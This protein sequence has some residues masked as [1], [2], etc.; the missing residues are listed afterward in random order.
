MK[1]EFYLLTELDLSNLGSQMGREIIVSVK[2]FSEE[3]F[4][5]K[6]VKNEFEHSK[7]NK[8]IRWVKT[9]KSIRCDL[10]FMGYEIKKIRILK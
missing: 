10:G 8:L 7:L 4:A 2:L 1:N 9:S 5:K 3:K 6:Y